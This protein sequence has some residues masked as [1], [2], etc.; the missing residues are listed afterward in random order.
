MN[1]KTNT[2]TSKDI[3][4][5]LL[6]KLATVKS[7]LACR[8][9]KNPPKK[10]KTNDN[11]DNV[12]ACRTETK[13]VTNI[14][15]LNQ[16]WPLQCKHLPPIKFTP[17]HSHAVSQTGKRMCV[18]AICCLVTLLHV[19]ADWRGNGRIGGVTRQPIDEMGNLLWRLG[20]LASSGLVLRRCGRRVYL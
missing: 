11:D 4:E 5:N 20:R 3:K 19:V 13:C 15:W 17:A 7:P 18:R 16:R 9:A 6:W 14:T 10:T 12:W 8:H 2:M 1:K